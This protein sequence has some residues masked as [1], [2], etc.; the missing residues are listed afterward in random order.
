MFID[1]SADFKKKGFLVVQ[2]NSRPTNATLLFKVVNVVFCN[3]F[4][5]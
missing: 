4:I 5:I 1:V 2:N 3:I